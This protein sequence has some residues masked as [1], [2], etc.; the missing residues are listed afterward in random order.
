MNDLPGAPVGPVVPLFLVYDNLPKIGSYPSTCC[1][2]LLF[3]PVRP[4]NTIPPPWTVSA[5]VSV[6]G[7]L[8][9]ATPSTCSTGAPE[10]PV[11]LYT[12]QFLIHAAVS[13]GKLVVFGTIPLSSTRISTASITDELTTGVWYTKFAISVVVSNVSPT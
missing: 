8:I 9:F 1:T 2:T 6:K 12:A 5:G 4:L 10:V 13:L 7:L 11:S 3:P